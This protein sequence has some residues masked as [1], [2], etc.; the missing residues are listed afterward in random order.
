MESV[1]TPNDIPTI[2]LP[3][4]SGK[5]A[6]KFDNPAK[7][8]DE[9]DA[10]SG[11]AKG[12]LHSTSDSSSVSSDY[13]ND[14][15]EVMSEREPSPVNPTRKRKRAQS[16]TSGS[17]TQALD[18]PLIENAQLVSTNKA[19][20]ST[21]LGNLLSTF[22]DWS[23]L[24]YF[25]VS[26]NQQP[27]TISQKDEQIQVAQLLVDQITQSS[28]DHVFDGQVG[29]SGLDNE[30]YPLRNILEDTVFTDEVDRLDLKSYA[31]LQN[32]SSPPSSEGLT[33]RQLPQRKDAAKGAI[34]KLLPPHLRIRRGK[35][36]L[37]ALPPAVS[38][39]ETFDLE[40]AHGPKD[41]SAY[42][43]HPRATTDAADAFLERLGLL[44]S[45]CNLG[46]HARGDMCFERGLGSW[47]T[48]T[49][50]YLST[51]QSLRDLCEELGMLIFQRFLGHILTSTFRK[52]PFG[53]S[54][55][56]RELRCLRD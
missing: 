26:Q 36:Y 10:L 54:A 48:E 15:D 18:N 6:V 29:L 32:G 44:Y 35:G 22:S 19:D 50:N 16:N 51:V 13:D 7:V 20:N 37:E 40:P 8:T 2:G 33:P 52:R 9:H 41:I 5:A 14:S 39:W 55:K 27:P 24:G 30:M 17:I 34:S 28:L 45:A 46:N 49:S 25:S 23:L 56:D 43:I 1:N 31:S 12:S 42:C 11:G 38:F 3:R 53:Q 4:R 47:N 21:F